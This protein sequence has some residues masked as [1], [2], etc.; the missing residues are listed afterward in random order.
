MMAEE[1]ARCLI[2]MPAEMAGGAFLLEKV[3]HAIKLKRMLSFGDDIPKLVKSS[4]RMGAK[5]G[6]LREIAGRGTRN[7]GINV[8]TSTE[9]RWQ[10]FRGLYTTGYNFATPPMTPDPLQL[11]TYAQIKWGV[12]TA[13]V[14]YSVYKLSKEIDIEWSAASPAGNSLPKH[15][16]VQRVEHEF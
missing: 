7:I 13:A 4:K 9:P 5:V 11:G 12:P 2:E 14:G 3:S 6:D 8:Y 10:A 15:N 1:S 16:D